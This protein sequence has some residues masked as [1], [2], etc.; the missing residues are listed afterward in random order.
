MLVRLQK[1]IADRGYCSRRKAE[2]YITNKLVK[3]K[4]IVVDELGAKFDEDKVVIEIDGH[5]LK[6]VLDAEKYYFLV[7]KPL[8]FVTSLK[9]DRGRKTV[10]MLVPSRYGR[11][12]PV[13]RLDINTSGALIM[14]ND[15]DFANLVMH[16][17]SQFNKT[18]LVVI[19]GIFTLTDKTRLEK[20]IMLEDGLTAPAKV[21]VVS[22]KISTSSVLITIHEGKNREVRRMMEALNHGII[23][24]SR[25]KI[26]GL[27]VAKLKTGQYAKIPV[28]IIDKIKETCTYNRDHN[29]YKKI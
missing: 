29:T 15:G 24:L 20:G 28:S 10:D 26:G 14:T 3:I 2:E 16:P 11:L 23:S 9:D 22:S 13:G 19:R 18:Y 12:F 21:K 5:L 4:G 1:I 6:P 27:S 17:S 8:G 7:N 25:R